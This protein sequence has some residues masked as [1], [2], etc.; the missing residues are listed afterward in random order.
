MIWKTY[1]SRRLW[2][3][4]SFYQLY[5][6]D[7]YLSLGAPMTLKFSW[8]ALT[9]ATKKRTR[10][11]RMSCSLSLCDLFGDDDQKNSQ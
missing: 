6:T 11:F 5:F 8:S 9:R 4:F 2:A 1:G 3:A 7:I 10:S